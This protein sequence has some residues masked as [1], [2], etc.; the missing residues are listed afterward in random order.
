MGMDDNFLMLADSEMSQN[1]GANL[2]ELS[3]ALLAPGSVDD[4]YQT[5]GGSLTMQSLEGMLA[6][7][8][9]NAQDFTLWQ[10]MNKIKAFSTVEEYDQ[11][12][13]LGISD[14]GFVG[15][16]ENPEFADADFLKQVAIVK[17][18]SE[19]W[20]VGDVQE[21]TQTI[22]QV[23]SRQQRSAMNRLLRNLNRALYNGNSTW[24]PESI[25]GLAKTISATSS[26]QIYDMRGSSVSMNTFNGIGQLI[27]EGNGHAENA[28]VYCSPAGIQNL[29][30]I[31]ESTGDGTNNRKII[32][33][34]DGSVTIGGKISG[35]MTNFG[36]MVPRLDK[37]LGME[38][39]GQRVPMYY[40]NS[41]KTWI[42][43]ATSEKAPA[44]P[45][46]VLTNQTAVSGSEFSASG[47]RPSG[48]TMRYRVSARNKYGR[49]K[50]CDVVASGS[51]VAAAGAISIAITP[52]QFDSGEKM[53]SCFVIYAEKVAGSGVYQYMDTVAAASNPLDVATYVDKN[54]YIPG[55]ARMYVIDQ[56]TAGE[57]RVMAYSQLLPIHN[58]DLAKVGRYTQ[59][60]INMYGA[61]KYY[62]PNVLVEIRNIGVSQSNPNL[63][64]TI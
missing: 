22:I 55:C 43:G 44:T 37:I 58:T 42:E 51:A 36:E 13:G 8:T 46:I 10:D 2:A 28:K 15:Q 56:T 39:E 53:P 52:N 63:F 1:T 49:S 29:S 48:Q 61:V 31:I 34:G 64:N 5:P 3:K 21:A 24:I 47:V 50:A 62:K 57:S 4:M 40:N 32:R 12:I 19:G 23:R 35:I 59:G 17:F 18:M 7:L 6:D 54:L 60:L 45:S 20:K 25:D 11:Q 27:T 33:S 9:L 38:Y 14:G 16:M 26:D 30:T 41:T